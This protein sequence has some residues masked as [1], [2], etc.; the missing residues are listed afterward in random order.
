MKYLMLLL[1]LAGCSQ[2]HD[3]IHN[4]ELAVIYQGQDET[5]LLRYED[6]QQDVVCYKFKYD[7]GISCL[8][9]ENK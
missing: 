7:S 4:G 1:L 6:R 9:K 5:R 2:D 3:V 8:H